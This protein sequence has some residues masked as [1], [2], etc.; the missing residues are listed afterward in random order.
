MAAGGKSDPLGNFDDG[1][2]LSPKSR[3]DFVLYV[4]EGR[5]YYALREYEMKSG[6]HEIFFRAIKRLILCN[7]ELNQ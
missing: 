2:L 7:C 3:S 4:L 6:G 1:F 5:E